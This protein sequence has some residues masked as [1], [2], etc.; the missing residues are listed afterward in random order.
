MDAYGFRAVTYIYNEPRGIIGVNNSENV[1]K[2]PNT[3]WLNAGYFSHA[4]GLVP[5]HALVSCGEQWIDQRRQ[6]K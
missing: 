6:Q 3:A 1:S 4:S 2:M 5:N